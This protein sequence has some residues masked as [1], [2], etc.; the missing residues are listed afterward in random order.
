MRDAVLP[1]PERAGAGPPRLRL[2]QAQEPAADV[3][4]HQ[5]HRPGRDQHDHRR[6]AGDRQPASRPA[7]PVGL[8]CQ[9][10]AGPGAPADRAPGGAR[11]V[12]IRRVP[13]GLPLL[14]PDLASRAAALQP[15]RRVPG[16][17]RPGGHGRGHDL[18]AGGRPVRGLRL[19][20]ALPRAARVAGSPAAAGARGRGRGHEAGAGGEAPPHRGRRRGDLRRAPRR[21]STRLR[22][23]SGSRS[24]RPRRARACCPGTIR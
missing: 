5:L 13:A 12:G 1:A 6:R 20:G 21:R 22:P 16:A 3:C 15:A 10:P 19:A 8:L 4:L 7:V 9:P 14:R 11:R 17:D 18:A 23:R 24:A 2:C